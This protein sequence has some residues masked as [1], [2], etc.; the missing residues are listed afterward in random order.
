MSAT[1][2]KIPCCTLLISTQLFYT[3]LSS[4]Q[5]CSTLLKYALLYSTY[6]AVLCSTLL[7]PVFLYSATF[8]HS[9]IS[10]SHI[11]SHFLIV[12]YS[13]YACTYLVLIRT[14]SL[15]SIF[16][17]FLPQSNQH[18]PHT[19]YHFL[20]WPISFFLSLS[21]SPSIALPPSLSFFLSRSLHSHSQMLIAVV[22][23]KHSWRKC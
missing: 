14:Y 19:I 11:N 2:S 12:L 6:P 9:S 21:F 13:T 5:S 10:H 23:L 1:I 15:L 17:I 7:L 4:T 3:L 8:S 20:S 16:C 18:L 22:T